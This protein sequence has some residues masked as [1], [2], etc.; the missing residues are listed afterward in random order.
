MKIVVRK[1]KEEGRG[2]E[3]ATWLELLRVK[4]VLTLA[5]VV[6]SKGTPNDGCIEYPVIQCTKNL[7]ELALDLPTAL[8]GTGFQFIEIDAE[9]A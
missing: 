1:V 3:P 8:Q 9:A 6:V 5:G 4:T 7:G 2:A